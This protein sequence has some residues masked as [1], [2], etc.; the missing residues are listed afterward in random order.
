[1]RCVKRWAQ[2]ARLRLKVTQMVAQECKW[3]KKIKYD[4]VGVCTI[5]EK[6]NEG[7]TGRARTLAPPRL[8]K[9]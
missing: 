2:C 6:N 3:G 7:D 4:S 1:M 9:V 8:C 5:S